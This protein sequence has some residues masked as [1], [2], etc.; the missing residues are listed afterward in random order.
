MKAVARSYF[1]WNGF[2]LNIEC[3]A[4]ACDSGQAVKPSQPVAPLHPWAWPDT[5]WRR[6]HVD[7]AGPF[8]GN[9]FFIPVHAHSKWPEVFTMSTTTSLSSL[10]SHYGLPEQIVSDNGPQFTSEEFGHFLKRHGMH[11]YLAPYH[12]AKIVV[13]CIDS[14]VGDCTRYRNFGVHFRINMVP[15]F[16][17]IEFV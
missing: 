2:N 4:K 1:W 5:P 17:Y 15:A 16:V 8:L 7:V 12:S 13:H 3:L 14:I 6:L 10:F 11:I 9:V